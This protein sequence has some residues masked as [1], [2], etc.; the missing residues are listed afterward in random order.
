MIS[1]STA[2]VAALAVFSSVTSAA[3]SQKR[4]WTEKSPKYFHESGGTLALLHYDHRYFQGEVGYTEHRYILRDAIRSYLSVMHEHKVETWLAHGTLLGWWWNGQI[5]PWD[6]DL[7][8][9]LTNTGMQWLAD[10][11]N[12]TQHTWNG[13]DMN[14]KPVQRTYLLDVNPHHSDMSKGDGQN[15]IDAR[16]IDTETG[17]FADLTVVRERD[18]SRPGLWSCKNYHRYQ[19]QDLWPMR[20][21]DFE[22]VTAK[23]PYNFESILTG[24]YSSNAL[25]NEEYHDHRWD[26]DIKEWVKTDADDDD[27]KEQ[28][29]A[30]LERKQ[31]ELASQGRL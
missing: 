23:I 25:T 12:N 13:T 27:A 21:T 20:L 8:V 5:M 18:S 11:L 22:G 28:R 2:L 30:A 15:I 31:S 29:K 19:T 17:M 26:H 3:P 16:W 24:E 4:D 9:Q 10:N 7:D 6:Y 1:P 14:G